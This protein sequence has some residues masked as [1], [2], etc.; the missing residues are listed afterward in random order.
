[1]STT[2][3]A[4]EIPERI[5]INVPIR[6]LEKLSAHGANLAPARG[7][8]VELTQWLVGV[9][10]RRTRQWKTRWEHECRLTLVEGAEQLHERREE[11]LTEFGELHDN[12][13]RAVQLVSQA[14]TLAGRKLC[15]PAQ[16]SEALA[17]LE[18][19]KAGIL[20][21][22]LTLED[23]E[24]ILVRHFQLPKAKLEA[25]GKKHPPPAEWFANDD[26]PF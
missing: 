11:L 1:M 24:A 13:R 2:T 23:L 25:I 19:F 22:W 14:E 6:E 16:L 7:L 3:I 20:D 15:D 21:R 12:L 5:D 10:L 18:S 26:N 4:P 8:F 17:E 9:L